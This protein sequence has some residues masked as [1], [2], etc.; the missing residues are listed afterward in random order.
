[1]AAVLLTNMI[2]LNLQLKDR[3]GFILR[4]SKENETVKIIKKLNIELKI[5]IICYGKCLTN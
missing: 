2:L 1:M 3:V 4:A 5:Y